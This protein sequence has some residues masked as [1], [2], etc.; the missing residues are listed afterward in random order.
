M[1]READLGQDV[2]STEGASFDDFALRRELLMGI[3]TY[4]FEKP[5]PIQ[6]KAIPAALEGRD[7]LARAK[8]G[9][10]KVGPSAWWHCKWSEA[11]DHRLH[12]SSS[13]H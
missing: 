1:S 9:T 4:G 6:E 8:N 12:H 10:G 7:I 5:S 11:D 13:L 3:F 2:T